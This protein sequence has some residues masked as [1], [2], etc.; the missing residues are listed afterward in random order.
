MK[1][2]VTLSLLFAATL[3]TN[4]NSQV[5]ITEDF[6]SPFTLNAATGWT[7]QNNSAP[8]GTSGWFQGNG[9]SFFAYNGGPNDYFGA[10]FASTT[11]SLGV[12]SNWLI[13]PAVT[14]YDGAVFQFATRVPSQATVNPDGLQLRMSTINTNVIP[15]GPNNVGSFTDLLLDINPNLTTNTNSAVNNGSVNGYPQSWAVYSVQ[16]SGVTGTVTGR[17]AFRYLVGNSAG[18]NGTNSNYIGVDA[19][20]Y[21]LPCGVSANNY[22]TCLGNSVDILTSGGLPTTSY[23]WSNSATSSSITVTPTATTVYT[24]TTSNVNGP[25]PNAV[26]VTVTLGSSLSIEASASAYTVCPGRTVTLTATGANNYAWSTGS[27]VIGAAAVMTVSPNSTSIYIVGGSSGNCTGTNTIT[28]NTLASPTLAVASSAS[29]SC[30]GTTLGLSSSGASFYTWILGNSVAGGSLVTITTATNPAGSTF[31]VGLIGADNNGCVSS[32]VITRTIAPAPSLS[33]TFSPGVQCIN[34]NAVLTVSGA[35]TYTWS[36]ATTSNSSSVT[37][38]N[39]A[40]AGP[41]SFTIAGTSTAGCTAS[42]TLVYTVSACTGVE[43]INGRS[44]ESSVFPNPFNSTL[45]LSGI[46]GRVDIYNALGQMVLSVTTGENESIN[47]SD[48]SKGAYILRAY[49]A[50]SDVRTIKLIKE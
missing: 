28:I 11:G 32:G 31:T 26:T 27:A 49:T 1:K 18:P 47:T 9:N 34:K 46:V 13:S 4:S 40:T 39:G 3:F 7:V 2:N 30:P 43:K 14:I 23:L 38:S 21:T 20:R 33:A 44:L 12:I 5:L 19:V 6:N 24:L 36:G 41:K 42:T 22:T 16:I 29:I 10:N 17:F 37:F 8:T 45:N 48:L 25:C 35:N 15:A 50:E